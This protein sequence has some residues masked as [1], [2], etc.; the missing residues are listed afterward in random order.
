M[1]LASVNKGRYVRR[2]HRSAASFSA[3]VP[4]MNLSFVGGSAFAGC[5]SAFCALAVPIGGRVGGSRVLTARRFAGL[6]P[7]LGDKVFHQ[8]V[9]NV[10][11]IL[12]RR[13]LHKVGGWP[14]E[15]A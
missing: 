3:T 13:R 9:G 4:I 5:D 6:A 1:Q 12:H 8:I 14:F 7:V 15:G 10:V 11:R 2:G